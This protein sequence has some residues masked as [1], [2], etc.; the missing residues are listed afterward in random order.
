MIYR[1]EIDGLRSI[2]VIAI[3]LFHTEIDLFSKAFIGVD[4][5]FVISGYLI[6]GLI[7]S[8]QKKGSFRLVDFYRRRI[9]R[10]LPAL[11]LLMLV[12]IPFAYSWMFAVQ[13]KDFSQSLVAA[14]LFSSNI[15]FWL[16]SQHY[17]AASS[18]FK[19]L[20][21]TWSLAV[22]EQF[23]LLYPLLLLPTVRLGRPY[24]VL[25]I[26]LITVLSACYA[27][28]YLGDDR[29]SQYY[30]PQAR[31][32][33]FGVGALVYFTVQDK[34]YSNHWLAG[35]IAQIG[36]LLFFLPIILASNTLFFDTK[37]GVL[38]WTS[39][40][41]IGTVLI[42]AFA[43]RN[44][45]VGKILS[46]R[47]LVGLGLISYS[48]YL[49]HFPIFV[50][51]RIRLFDVSVVMYGVL[52]ALALLLSYLSWRWVETPFRDAN[53]VGNKALYSIIVGASAAILMVGSY[54]LWS[55]DS[56]SDINLKADHTLDENYGL[57]RNCS[58]S[59]TNSLC[60]TSDAPEI[61]VWGDSFAM[62]IV[63]GLIE[64]YPKVS[65]I[66]FTLSACSPVLTQSRFAVNNLRF[67]QR[68]RDCK[69]FNQDVLTSL[70]EVKTLRYAIISSRFSNHFARLHF[71]SAAIT[72][73]QKAEE[74]QALLAESIRDFEV[75]LGKL[76]SKGIAAV[77]VSEPARPPG[78]NIVCAASA[79]KFGRD[80]KPCNFLLSQTSDAQVSARKMLKVIARQHKVIWLDELICREDDCFTVLDGTPIY[81]NGGHLSREGSALI[82]KKLNLY[83]LLT[84]DQR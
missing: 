75:V 39:I 43:S 47:P 49:W 80:T 4:V 54:G 81:T 42:I 35:G 1:P 51:A 62:H 84:E 50:F 12:C 32:W 7:V 76:A 46:V 65:L 60:Q 70:D 22:E 78:A 27:E 66:Q 55:A 26:T 71:Q 19:P 16:E 31:V 2:A 77:I 68:R 83:K 58:P 23:Y 64:S 10:L 53:R 57:A 61:A 44:N 63:D 72:A 45:M 6:T 29:I 37:I 69:Q 15:L 21:H 3:V 34:N 14:T 25:L 59:D 79:V 36:I 74:E 73:S 9:R 18:S 11:L 41:I 20:L 30:L 33:L 52:A 24:A 5:F 48:L 13:Q 17:F 40:S 67:Q 28:F 82:G 8:K 56:F 38:S